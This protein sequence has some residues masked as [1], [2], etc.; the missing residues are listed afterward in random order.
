MLICELQCLYGTKSSLFLLLSVQVVFFPLYFFPRVVYNGGMKRISLCLLLIILCLAFA[1]PSVAM[2]AD[3]SHRLIPAGGVMVY[4]VDLNTGRT[5]EFMLPEGYTIQS[6]GRE[7]S[8][9]V[10]FTYKGMDCKIK[11]AEWNRLAI[12]PS[13]K[14][15]PQITVTTASQSLYYWVGE[16]RQ[17]V[18]ADADG[19]LYYLGAYSK[20]SINYFA[21]KKSTDDYSVFYVVAGDANAEEINSILYPTAVEPGPEIN[22]GDVTVDPPEKEEGFTWVRFLLILGI[23]IPAIVIIL[24]I[25]RSRSRRSRAHREIYDEDAG[26]DSIDD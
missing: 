12:A 1:C 14:E 23:I 18:E 4:H 21:V 17:Y 16:E 9:Y 2:A 19:T 11:V 15:V 20:N 24:M 6:N 3:T 13:A 25:V 5:S 10:F 8:E 26:Y 22:Q 7:S